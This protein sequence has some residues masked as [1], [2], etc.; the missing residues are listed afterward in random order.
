[1][2]TAISIPDDLFD[3]AERLARKSGM[4]R[5][6]LYAEALRDFLQR[7]KG[8]S[9]TAQLDRVYARDHE[10]DAAAERAALADLPEEEW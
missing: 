8:E 3:A 5:S 1:M 7:K 2:K 6:Q 9:V 4:S 10:R